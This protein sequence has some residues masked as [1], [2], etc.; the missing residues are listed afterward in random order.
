[1]PELH[2]TLSFRIIVL[3]L[4]CICS[5]GGA[6]ITYR[7]TLPPV[8]LPLRVVLISLRSLGL[9]S[10]F[11]LIGEPLLSLV[12]RSVDPPVVAVLIDNSQSMTIKDRTG[13]RDHALKTAVHSPVW[14]RVKAEGTLDYFLFDGKARR[15]TS[16]QDDS[17]SLG[18]QA[19]DIAGALKFLK[20]A[21]LTSNLQA[22]VLMT[23]GN[24]TV[25]MNPLYEAKD[26][27]IPV[28]TIGIGDTSDQKDIL[29]RKVLAN[30]ITY[31]GS[32]VPVHVIVHSAGFGG[33]RIQVSLR[34][35]GV[36][37]DQKSLVL[38]SGIQDY[39][40]PL[41]FVSDK[42]G[43]QRVDAD[44]SELAGELTTHNNRSS[45]IVKVLK[46]KLHITLIAGAPNQDVACLKD[47]LEHD[48]KVNLTSFI[49]REDGIFYEGNLTQK[50]L[51]ETD[52]LLLAG[53]P[54]RQTNSQVV[55]TIMN[56]VNAGKPI[57]TLFSRTMDYEKLYAFN[58]VLPFQI[59][60][61]NSNELQIFADIP[62]AQRNNSI[63]QIG[64]AAQAFQLWSKLPPI[65]QLQ[66]TYRGKVESDIIATTRFQSVV[67]NNPLIVSRNV[68]KRKSLSILGYGIWRWNMLSSPGT[69]TDNVLGIFLNNAFRWL[70][71]QEDSRRIVVQ[72]TKHSFTTQDPVEFTAQ[73][74]DDKYQPLEDVQVDVY[75]QRGNTTNQLILN[76]LGSGQYQGAYDQLPAGEYKFSA[77]VKLNGVII[78]TDQGVFSVGGVNAE[79]I[80]T[81]MNKSLLQQIAIQTDGRYY[82]SYNIEALPQDITA[83]PHF[84][85][86]E[87]QK[88]TD[89]EL[90]NSRWILA[91]VILIFSIEWF[92]RKRSGML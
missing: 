89:I 66:G 76:S 92:L 52:C 72:P 2:F 12:T 19:T 84:K 77:T 24:S 37:L 18:G 57:L 83:S 50:E 49:E 79:Y 71:T 65:F 54:T 75:T 73:I 39:L 5:I 23:D 30:E 26:L 3:L 91:L 11:L 87:L 10:L 58:S 45:F 78:G 42:E 38:E 13:P 17:L 33:E 68:N 29:I 14:D 21:S 80:D 27:G 47:I 16:V 43:I 15:V 62:Q 46:S 88:S 8:S 1:M 51:T 82:E 20:Q 31:A 55:Q 61:V 86:R 69:G 22:I 74:Y 28:F 60:N 56:A 36:V 59:E 85:Q 41:S 48:T 44:I 7:S 4:G 32:K 25:G 34:Q 64:N 9:M 53:F 63:I 67:T 90:W 6:L 40:V 81:K 35:E 70:T